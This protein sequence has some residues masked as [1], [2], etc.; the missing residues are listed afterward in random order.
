MPNLSRDVVHGLGAPSAAM[1]FPDAK[2]V[3][4]RERASYIMTNETGVSFPRF[5]KELCGLPKDMSRE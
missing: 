5:Y 1:T 2:P 3:L 4:P